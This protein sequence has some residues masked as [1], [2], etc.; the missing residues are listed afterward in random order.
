[1]KEAMMPA[2]KST[3]KT[4]H[5]KE[6]LFGHSEVEEAPDGQVSREQYDINHGRGSRT[7]G[8]KSL[9]SGRSADKPLRAKNPARKSGNPIR[10]TNA[11]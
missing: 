1:M 3:P 9:G 8:T 10:G 7:S 5:A 4:D 6:G 2:R 11:E